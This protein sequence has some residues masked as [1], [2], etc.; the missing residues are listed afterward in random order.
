MDYIQN[1]FLCWDREHHQ[2]HL[3]GYPLALSPTE[4]KIIEAIM[5]DEPIDMYFTTV[6]RPPLSKQNLAVHINAINR[7]A[8]AISGR[9]LVEFKNG[10]YRIVIAM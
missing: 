5:L 6:D 8:S 10:K 2:F 7:K 3:L 1:R 9:K 4:S